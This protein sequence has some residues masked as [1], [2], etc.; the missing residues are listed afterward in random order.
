M[1]EAIW[2]SVKPSDPFDHDNLKK[3]SQEQDGG[4]YKAHCF[5]NLP[6][7]FLARIS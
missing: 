1:K 4:H 6:Y 5:E 3:I 7:C 2:H